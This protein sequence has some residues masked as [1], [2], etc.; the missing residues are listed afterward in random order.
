MQPNDSTP[1]S[2]AVW[3]SREEYERLRAHQQTNI[4]MQTT[5]T[6]SQVVTSTPDEEP[7]ISRTKA[8]I[9]GALAAVLFL[10]VSVSG[11]RLAFIPVLVIFLAYIVVS[12]NDVRKARI[13]HQPPHAMQ[14]GKPQK[15]LLLKL[16]IAVVIIAAL[17][18]LG[19][20]AMIAFFIAIFALNGGPSS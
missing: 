17:P 15:S 13:L 6:P 2:D 3:I 16:V 8:I 12:L 10:S 1:Q 18:I 4:S 20:M 7:H 14:P 11:I 5:Q 9:G 19:Y